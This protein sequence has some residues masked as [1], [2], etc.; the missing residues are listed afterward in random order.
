[1]RRTLLLLLALTL[2]GGWLIA[3]AGSGL[4]REH[5]VSAGVPLDVVRPRAD[6]PRPGV[7]V[8]HGFSGSAR[9]M[10][11]FGDSL[12]ARGYVVA[13]L[14][15]AGHGANTEPLPD[16]A[17][18]TDEST[19]A[20]ER[21]LDAAVAH[22]RSLPDVDPSR[23]GL[24]GHSMGA[25]AVTRYAAAHPDITATVAISLPG[26]S[27]ASPQRPARLLTMA[28]ALEFPGFREVATSVAAQ[29]DDR[30]AR[31]VAGVEHITILYAPET[32]RATV[33]WLDEA[34]GGQ[35][36]GGTVPF[37]GRRLLGSALLVL[38]VL[39]G[40][41]PLVAALSGSPASRSVRP[42]S[43]PSNS[44]P[45]GSTPPGSARAEPAA[46]PTRAGS[47]G[48]PLFAGWRW[49]AA[50]R[51]AL[52]A[53]VAAG[54]GAVVARFLPTTRMPLAIAG[55]VTAYAAVTGALLL[56]YARWRPTPR[57]TGTAPPGRWW[58]LAVVPYSV[59]G[60]GVPVHLGLTHALL[61]GSRWWLL[62]VVWAA[63][64]LLAYGAERIS[65]G[66]PSSL[67]AVAGSFTVVLAAAAVAGLTHGFVTLVLVPL[68]GLLLWQVW[69]SA[70]LNRFAAPAWLIA[71]TGSVVVTWPL[72]VT[73]PLT[74]G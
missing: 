25:G 48:R 14:D 46:A 61:A 63:F 23:I 69:W 4:D 70:I 10:A 67:L 41:H 40:F 37:P 45:P 58:L 72:L 27:A 32:H 39:L 44:A 13:L 30:E 26:S 11:P 22:L 1:M 62:V 12:A 7:V 17:A 68:T 57:E 71:V 29:R 9:M 51:V 6:G 74:G 64:A 66:A 28:G 34:F 31:L 60:I 33:S 24:V 56:A 49:A 18:G 53:G 8:A 73:L 47:T 52:I 19:R 21:D 5:V 16:E 15:F 59:L 20:L 38:A 35:P 54:V 36:A 43:A 65:G 3:G 50:I 55:Y 42:G 2:S